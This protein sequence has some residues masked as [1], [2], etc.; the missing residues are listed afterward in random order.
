MQGGRDTG[1]FEENIIVSE[2]TSSC[3]SGHSQLSSTSSQ[4]ERKS[5]LSQQHQTDKC[6]NLGA[7]QPASS[8]WRAHFHDILEA[9]I[10]HIDEGRSHQNWT[11]QLLELLTPEFMARALRTSPSYKDIERIMRITDERMNNSSAPPLHV[12]VFG[13]SVTVGTGFEVVPKELKKQVQ[14]GGDLVGGRSCVWPNRFQLVAD[15]FSGKGV[16]QIDNLAVGGTASPQ[17]QPAISYWIYL[18]TWPLK[19]R[20][21]D[22]IVNAYATNNLSFSNVIR[23]FKCGSRCK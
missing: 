2:F 9:S 17:V 6:R 1:A 23:D 14:P 4:F 12:G 22:V 8:I 18:S 10:L 11:K 3:A 5:S 16:V 20:G 15:S 19:D 21:P 13:G 7:G